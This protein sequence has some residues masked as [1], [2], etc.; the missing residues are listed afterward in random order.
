MGWQDINQKGDV[1][2]S[3]REGS[4]TTHIRRITPYVRNLF[5]NAKSN[6]SRTV[7]VKLE[8]ESDMRELEKVAG[9]YG[10]FAD[11]VEVKTLKIRFRKG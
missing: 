10:Y 9:E 5:I 7:S 6:K 2:M 4:N 1:N 8:N 11:R 3:T